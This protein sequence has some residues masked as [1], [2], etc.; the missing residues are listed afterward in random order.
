MQTLEGARLHRERRVAQVAA[1]TYE[2][3]IGTGEQTLATYAPKAFALRESKGVRSIER[4]RQVFRDHIEPHLG[5]KALSEITP[6]DIERWLDVLTRA[7]ELAPKSVLN[8]HGVLSSVLVRARF[9]GLVPSIATRDLPPGTLPAPTRRRLRRAWRTA[10]VESLISDERVPWDRRVAYT[11][12]ACT[13]TRLGEVAGMR[14]QDI[15]VD[16]PDLWWWSLRTQY[17]GRP[18][19]GSSTRG[20]ERPRDVPIHPT[21]QRELARWRIEGWA[22]LV[23]RVP[24]PGDYVV[25]REDGSVHSD[26]SLGAKAVHRHAALL[27]I[28]DTERDFHSFRRWMITQSRAGGARDI[29]LER[30]THNAKGAMLDRYTYADWSELCSAIRCL[31]IEVRRSVVVPLRKASGG[32]GDGEDDP[33]GKPKMITEELHAKLHAAPESPSR[34]ERDDG[35]TPAASKNEEPAPQEAGSF[36]CERSSAKTDRTRQKPDRMRH[37]GMAACQLRTSRTCRFESSTSRSSFPSHGSAPSPGSRRA[38]KR[39]TAGTRMSTS[40]RCARCRRPATWAPTSS[41]KGSSCARW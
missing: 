25:P 35:S 5:G 6:R 41:R 12:A 37:V 7:G 27:G 34:L 19:K 29:Y 33:L 15:D 13:G 22:Q 23:G 24:R 11:I 2:P 4:E 17:D 14:W 10:E 30:I 16:A 3:G 9:D 8:A 31:R 21:L 20:G 32:G 18:L 28:D 26:N 39:S 40:G 1:G 38:S 36:V